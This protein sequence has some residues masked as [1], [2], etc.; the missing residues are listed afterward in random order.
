MDNSYLFF[1]IECANCFNGEGKM[2]SFGYILTDA[3]FN[4]LDSQDLVM[5]PE[6]EFDWYLFSN[7]NGCSLAYSKDYFRMQRPFPDYYKG[8]KNL[9]TA[10]S[11]KVIGFSSKNDLGFMVTACERY[12]FPV[13]NFATYDIAKILEKYEGKSKKLQ[14]WVDYFNIEKSN[15]VA[16]KSCDDAKMTML[17]LKEL[18]KKNNVTID[19]LLEKNRDSHLSVEKYLEH[20]EIKRHNDEVS[21]KIK[22][23]YGKKSKCPYSKSFSGC[24]S[25]GFKIFN[26]IDLSYDIAQLLYKHGGMLVKRLQKD[27][28]IIVEDSQITPE[29]L[30]KMKKDNLTVITV[31]EFYNKIPR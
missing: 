21:A 18:C 26:D 10:P 29:F 16:H 14:E 7:K 11:R 8:I 9:M 17:V 19:E 12:D 1:D 6:T 30:E 4:I 23:L 28:T 31:E 5:N 22:E 24:Y 3:E 27:G 25:F 20:R 2:C 15:L 13:F